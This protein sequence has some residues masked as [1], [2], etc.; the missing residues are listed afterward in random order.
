LY[1]TPTNPFVSVDIKAIKEI[2]PSTVGIATTTF[3]YTR[4][5]ELCTTYAAS[6]SPTP[7]VFYTI[8]ISNCKS[9]TL[10]VGISSI[11]NNIEKSFELSFVNI[12][13]DIFTSIY[14][15]NIL[16]N[17]GTVG[18]STNGSNIEFTYTGVVGIGVTLQTN[19][20]LLTNTYV[21]YDSFSKIFSKFVSS[22]ITTN[23]LS[24]GISTVS[25]IYGYSK[26]IMEIEQNTGITT[27]RSIVQ[28]N[29]IHAEDYVNNTVYDINGNISL[30]DLNFDTTYNI[31]G[32]NYTLF[33]NP[34]TSA[35]YKITF[36][37]SSLLSPNQ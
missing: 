19:L 24:I 14:S 28:I 26:Y 1:F 30:D 22:Q 36:Y 31:G 29:S 34:V 27:Q 10:I 15:E 21:G 35:T 23:S 17:L 33:F 4:N 12:S 6:G 32:N 16:N 8:P 25:G 3:G 9:G 13:N 7:Q 2:A 5:V 37:E 18:I 20:K 11:G